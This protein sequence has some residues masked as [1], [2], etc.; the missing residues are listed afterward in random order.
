MIPKIKLVFPDLSDISDAEL[1][2]IEKWK[3]KCI[4]KECE[5]CEHHHKDNYCILGRRMEERLK[6]VY[7]D[8]P[9]PKKEKVHV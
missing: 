9:P 8:W 2:K 7:G 1:R 5:G 3:N 4:D 6:R